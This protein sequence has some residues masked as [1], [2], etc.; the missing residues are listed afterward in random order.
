MTARALVPLL[1]AAVLIPGGVAQAS[2]PDELLATL[3]EVSKSAPNAERTIKVPAPLVDSLVR[4]SLS[5]AGPC[6]SYGESASLGRG[7]LTAYSQAVG[8]VPTSIGLVFTGGTLEGLPD[9]PPSDGMSCFDKN[10]DGT[11]DPHHECAGGYMHVLKLS[12]AFKSSADTPFNYLMANWNP[13]GHTPEGIWSV[14]HFDVH[15]YTNQIAETMAIRPGPCPVLV[16]CDD[17][18]AGKILPN[19]RYIAPGYKDVDALEPAMGNHLIDQ[20]SP[21]FHGKP[22]THTFLY[23]SWNGHLTFY[24]P[25]VTLAWYNGLRNGTNKDAC[26]PMKLPL[27]SEKAGWYPTTYCLRYRAN[28]DEF[29]TSLENFV[30]RPAT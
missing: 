20:T 23:G 14:P 2:A 26:S 1:L 13:I 9:H 16:N 5:Y 12:P 11:V 18:K 28:R 21:E 25:M 7:K 30:Y 17:Y 6:V 15:F 24:E 19:P 8:P 22:F 29:T 3:C 27:A 10:S 4:T